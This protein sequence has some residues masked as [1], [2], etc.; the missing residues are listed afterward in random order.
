MVEEL[1][2]HLKTWSDA[3]RT[4]TVE[5]DTTAHLTFV[6]LGALRA[7]EAA[8][9]LIKHLKVRDA[10]FK[11]HAS[12]EKTPLDT[13]FPALRALIQIGEPSIRYLLDAIA[14]AKDPLTIQLAVIGL[15]RIGG[16]DVAR[17]HLGS[18]HKSL[19][20][21]ERQGDEKHVAT[22]LSLVDMPTIVAAIRSQQ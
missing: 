7:S 19:R 22:A 16:V 6:L 10:A 11:P 14:F 18:S 4:D 2:A 13:H 20:S 12:D 1:L 5:S 8:P 3:E 17:F 15:I 9:I 21:R